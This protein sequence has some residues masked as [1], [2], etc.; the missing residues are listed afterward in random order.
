MSC[1]IIIISI[2][3][4][5][6]N[7]YYYYYYYLRGSRPAGETSSGGVV[8]RGRRPPGSRPTGDSSS[9]GDVL[10]GSRPK[11]ESS[12]R[13]RRPPTESSVGSCPRG[14]LSSGGLVLIQRNRYDTKTLSAVGILL[15]LEI[16]RPNFKFILSNTASPIATNVSSV[17]NSNLKN[18]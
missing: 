13:G 17:N 4:I 18:T 14:T 8:L 6:I 7:Y 1:I 15:L 3:I 11:G 5:I 16:F 12:Q 2:I 10:R 9:G